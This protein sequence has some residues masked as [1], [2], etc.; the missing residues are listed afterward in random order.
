MISRII[1]VLA[2]IFVS[3]QIV[4]AQGLLAPSVGNNPYLLA[5]G[6]GEIAGAVGNYNASGLTYVAGPYTAPVAL[7]I[8]V[9][10]S[11]IEPSA[12][13][14][15]STVNAKALNFNINDRGIYNCTN[16]VV[17]A[18]YNSPNANSANCQIADGLITAGTYATVI[19]APATVGGA[20][21]ADWVGGQL[22]QRIIALVNGLGFR[23]LTA[24]TGFTGDT[25]IFTHIG[26]T[27][28]FLGTA[29]AT[30][31]TCLRNFD[32]AF[33][34]A[35]LGTH[36]NFI[37]SESIQNNTASANITNAEADA[38]ASGCSNC[39]AGFNLD[40][41]TGGTNRQGDGTHLTAVGVAAEAAGDVA[42]VQ[43]CV[44]MTC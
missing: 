16:P 14:T 41:L 22:S 21:C 40:S 9:G 11:N 7:I 20:S 44:G 17:G 2:G 18:T 23:G 13:G 38:V 37:A 33:T 10:Q 6:N 35:G 27:D 1:S 25:F 30:M 5:I 43:G 36:R 29:R 26:E 34:T 42:K 3:V 19:M 39:R 24:A 8:T 31:A 32:A 4:I 15:Y 12:T 28:N